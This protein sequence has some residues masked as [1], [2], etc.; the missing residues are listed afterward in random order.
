MYLIPQS[1]P[2]VAWRVAARSDISCDCG[3]DPKIGGEREIDIAP[4]AEAKPQR[5]KE[6]VIHTVTARL[7]FE[8]RG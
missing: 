8:F 2:H 4:T 6:V 1:N 7:E 3:I 5:L